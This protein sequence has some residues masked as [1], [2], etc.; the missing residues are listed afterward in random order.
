[1]APPP[2]L[3]SGTSTLALVARASAFG[4]GLIY[5]NIKL[6]ALKVHLS[7]FLVLFLSDEKLFSLGFILT[8]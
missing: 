8:S 2:G 5:G 6:K 4:L 3:Y 1:M 7:I